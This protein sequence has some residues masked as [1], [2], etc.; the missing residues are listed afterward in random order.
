MKHNR[1]NFIQQTAAGS[2]ALLF[3]SLESFATAPVTAVKAN[4]GYDLKILATNWG[5]EGSM[6][7]FCAKA[8]K[9]TMVLKTGGPVQSRNR[10]KCLQ[11]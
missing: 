7:A 11:H 4:A 3:S 1:R 5:F 10:M 8:K 2:A 6:D 9:V